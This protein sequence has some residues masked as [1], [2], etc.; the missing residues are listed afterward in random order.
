MTTLS[1]PTSSTFHP[2]MLVGK[3]RSLENSVSQAFQTALLLSA[4]VERATDAVIEGMHLAECHELSADAL[5]HGA[6]QAALRNSGGLL[7]PRIDERDQ[8][9]RCLPPELVR[10]L[11]LSSG[12]R[13]CYVLRMLCGLSP[14]VCAEMLGIESFIVD[15]RTRSAAAVLPFML[16]TAV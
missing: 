8:A 6:L 14:A 9:S 1:T 12:L 13:H 3:Y 11:H 7:E 16:P 10:V 15:E 4:S 5:F 2:W